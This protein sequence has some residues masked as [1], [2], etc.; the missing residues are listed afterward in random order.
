MYC[1]YLTT[2]KG[3]KL[4]PFYIGSTSIK[5]IE[6]GYF[7]SVSSKLYK[8]TWNLEIKQ[9]PHLFKITIISRH[10]SRADALSK[11]LSFHKKL[12]VVD[13]QMY[14]NRSYA[15]INGFLVEMFQVKIIQCMEK[16]GLI[17]L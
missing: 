3:N 2:Y 7:G 15:C 4:P 10:T 14:T 13:S 5:N 12:N 11:E 17:H 6:N 1:V 8:Q 16:I 9:N